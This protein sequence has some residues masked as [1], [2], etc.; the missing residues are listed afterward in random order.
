MRSSVS[1]I[2]VL[3]VYLF[4]IQRGCFDTTIRLSFDQWIRWCEICLSVVGRASRMTEAWRIT[5]N[6]LTGY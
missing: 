5:V 3:I 2:I 6:R 4:E 1:N